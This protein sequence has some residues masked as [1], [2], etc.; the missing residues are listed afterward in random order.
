VA[1]AVLIDPAVPPSLRARPDPLTAAMFAAYFT[2]GVGKAVISGR[3]KVRTAEQ[4]ALETLKL[5]CSDYRRV[6]EEVIEAHFALARSRRW[7]AEIEQEFVTATRSLLWS[8]ARRRQLAA[9]MR[10]IRGPV[11]LLHGD[12]DRLVSIEAARAVARANPSWRFE[13]ANGV[14]HVPQLEVPQW[15]AGHLLDWLGTQAAVA[16][17]AAR[18]ATVPPARAAS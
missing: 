8:L 6:P 14:G 9:T 10:S 1:G 2:P 16:A 17:D 12:E 15:T 11:L 4:M 5:C 13:V 7:Y 18:T 3:R